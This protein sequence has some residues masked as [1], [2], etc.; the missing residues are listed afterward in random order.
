MSYLFHICFSGNG[1]SAPVASSGSSAPPLPPRVP[2]TGDAF[3]SS[4]LTGYG[5]NRSLGYGS[6]PY[7][8]YG[9]G[10]SGLSQFHPL[11]LNNGCFLLT[12]ILFIQDILLDMAVEWVTVAMEVMEQVALVE[13]MVLMAHMVELVLEELQKTGT[14]HIYSQNFKNEVICIK[15]H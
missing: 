14:V 12:S 13:G 4:A 5:A 6:S 2:G 7:G 10:Y 1:G 15:Q 8:S 9:G 11:L 3:G